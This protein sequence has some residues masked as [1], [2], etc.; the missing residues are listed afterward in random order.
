[1][2]VRID[3]CVCVLM[4]VTLRPEEIERFKSDPGFFDHVRYTLENSMNVSALRSFGAANLWSL[5]ASGREIAVDVRV[6]AA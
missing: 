3:I 4:V 1:M 6:H 5:T 2:T